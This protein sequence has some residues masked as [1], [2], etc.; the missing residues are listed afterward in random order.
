MLPYIIPLF[1]GTTIITFLIGKP[2]WRAYKRNKAK[3]LPF[4]KQWRKIIQ[5]RMPYF[6]KMP[7]HLQ[8]Q[9]K[10]H[11]QVFLAEKKFV[12]KNGVIITDEIKVTIA[13]QACLLL[14]TPN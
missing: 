2:Y 6:K 14:L 7:T 13:A 11:I 3:L 5:H 4:K 1:I 12:G 8:L 9:L 10:E